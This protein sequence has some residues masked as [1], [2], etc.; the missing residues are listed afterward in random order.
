M[1]L[2]KET[3]SRVRD[4]LTRAAREISHGTGEE[5]GSPAPHSSEAAKAV[6]TAALRLLAR[7]EHSN[8]ELKRKLQAKGHPA[9]TVA[10]VVATLNGQRLVSDERF[11]AGFVRHHAARG[12]GPVRIRAELRQH[13]I[14]ETAIEERLGESELDWTSLAAQV[15]RR[16]FGSQRPRTV[17]ERAKQARFLKYRGF[18]ADQIRAA[19]ASYDEREDMDVRLDL[20][21]DS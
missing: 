6:Q 8:E 5:T 12:Q 10:A 18:T 14:E 2:S 15:R 16:K 9:E 21:I 19:F 11:L 17:A 20:D 7:R 4:S 1:K 3:G 13:G